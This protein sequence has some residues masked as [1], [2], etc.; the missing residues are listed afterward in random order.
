[1]VVNSNVPSFAGMF[2]KFVKRGDAVTVRKDGYSIQVTLRQAVNATVASYLAN[3]KTR[4][5]Q[6]EKREA[7]ALARTSSSRHAVAYSSDEM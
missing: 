5:K 7:K 2:R 6:Q 3:A 4:M 1:M